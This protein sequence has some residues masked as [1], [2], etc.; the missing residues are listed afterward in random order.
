MSLPSSAG[1]AVYWGKPPHPR[2]RPFVD[3]YWYGGPTQESEFSIL[4]DGCADLVMRISPGRI[5]GLL[6]GSTTRAKD[7]AL[8]PGAGHLSIRFRPGQIR[9]FLDLTGDVWLDRYVEFTDESD[10]HLPDSSLSGN[11]LSIAA[12]TC[13]VS[14]ARLEAQFSNFAFTLPQQLNAFARQIQYGRWLQPAV[15]AIY[16]QIYLMVESLGCFANVTDRI[17]LAR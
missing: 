13:R 4:P 11:P 5:E 12:Q 2:L 16:N 15:A 14:A 6:L 10:L 1:A 17:V 7:F 3:R 9:N 8:E